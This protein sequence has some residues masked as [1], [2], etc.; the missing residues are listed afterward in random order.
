MKTIAIASQ[1][2]GAGKTTI[3]IHLLVLAMQQGMKVLIID[4]D[5]QGSVSAW[6]KKRQKNDP[7]DTIQLVQGQSERL[8][9]ILGAA[10]NEEYDFV[11]IDTPPHVAFEPQTAMQHADLTII[12][13]RPSVLDLEAIS[14][15]VKLAK[16]NQFPAAI[17][18]NGCRPSRGV[19]EN[20]VTQDARNALKAYE[21]PI[22]PTSI[23]NYVSLT[24]ALNNGGAVTEFAPDSKA[25]KEFFD[26]W[27]WLN[28]NKT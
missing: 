4:L 13:C 12:P 23:T 18:L 7:D 5:T 28:A 9:D 8:G 11:V 19:G 25:A 17:L 2:G 1:K 3:A 24:D 20:S 16:D 26:L 6:W 10:E 21:L 15:T 27:R 22:L 14:K